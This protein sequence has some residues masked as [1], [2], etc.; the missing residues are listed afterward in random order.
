V[1]SLFL[2][3]LIYI[4]SL[5]RPPANTL[6]FPRSTLY[7][8]ALAPPPCSSLHL[9]R[10]RKSRPTRVHDHGLRLFHAVSVSYIAHHALH[11][12]VRYPAPCGVALPCTCR[13]WR[14]T[15]FW[16]SST[17]RWCSSPSSFRFPAAF[18]STAKSPAGLFLSGS[19]S[20][21]RRHHLRDAA[22]GARINKRGAPGSALGPGI[23]ECKFLHPAFQVPRMSTGATPDDEPAN[24]C[25]GA[26]HRGA[27]LLAAL[28]LQT[29]L[30]WNFPPPGAAPT[31]A[32]L[33]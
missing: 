17:C 9:H 25:R 5:P 13:S 12:D 14:A 16:R 26:I 28:L 29:L 6:F 20:R 1:A 31:A 22:P 21:Y 27:G 30:R 11:G 2:F 18:P 33:R 8:T 32:G 23:S 7:S 19:T 10:A 15:S 4:S 3:W 24:S